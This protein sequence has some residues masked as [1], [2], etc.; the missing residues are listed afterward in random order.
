ML[1]EEQIQ[2]AANDLYT[3]EI[4]RQQIEPISLRYPDLTIAEAYAIQSNWV[5]KKIN[6][7]AKII[8]YKVG[9]TSRAMQTTMN[10]DTP[11]YGVLLDDMLFEDSGEIITANFLDPRVEPEL[12]FILKK[13]LYGDKLNISDVLNATDYVVPAI[14]LIAAR[15]YRL[16]PQTGYKRTVVD[17]IA[18]NAANAG[19]ILGGRPMRPDQ[20][21]LRWCGT[22]LY[23][24]E[25]IEATGLSAA[26]LNHPANGVRW[27]A[28]YFAQHDIA[29]QAGQIILS[30]SFTTAVKVNAK[31]VVYADYGKLGNISIKFT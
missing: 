3:A 29:L 18:D 17:T 14:E 25:V 23:V 7:G 4:E 28:K 10:I 22:I 6:N 31:D 21:D 16:H 20:L 15:S 11:D 30:G 13:E 26:V 2:T 1:T 12:A 8:G 9:L 5:N 24:N 19:V 27:A